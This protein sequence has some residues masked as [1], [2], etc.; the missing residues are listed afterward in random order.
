MRGQ[1]QDGG[2][3]KIYIDRPDE[4]YGFKHAICWLPQYEWE[5][6]Y[7]FTEEEIKQFEEMR[8]SLSNQFMYTLQKENRLEMQPRYGLPVQG[9][10]CFS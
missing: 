4:Q 2:R 5:D 9:N 3:V 10:I 1:K 7:H 6:V 8:T